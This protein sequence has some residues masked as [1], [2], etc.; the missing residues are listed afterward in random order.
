MIKICDN[1][2]YRGR[3]DFEFV[4]LEGRYQGEPKRPW[5]YLHLFKRGFLLTILNPKIVRFETLN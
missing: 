2:L 5:W 4:R 3:R 1:I